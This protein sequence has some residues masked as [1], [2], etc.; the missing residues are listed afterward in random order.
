[1]RSRPSSISRRIC[2]HSRSNVD[3]ARS[4]PSDPPRA[5]RVQNRTGSRS[6]SSDWTWRRTIA[7]KRGEP[8]AGGSRSAGGRTPASNRSRTV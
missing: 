4:P 8:L 2:G 6:Q 1:M 7:L 5:V 3:A